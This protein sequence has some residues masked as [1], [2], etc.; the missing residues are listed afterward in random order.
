MMENFFTVRLQDQEIVFRKCESGL[1]YFD[2]EAVT[3]S[4]SAIITS[5]D[6]STLDKTCLLSTM[7]KNRFWFTPYQF[8]RYRL[9]RRIYAM[10]CR[11]SCRDFQNVVHSH[12]IKNI[13][14]TIE[15]ITVT[16]SIFGLDLS[17]LKNK[18][19]RT[20]PS[21]VVRNYAS[22]PA[23]IRLLHHYVN[24]SV[25]I[26]Y[27]KSLLLLVTV[28]RSLKY[29]TLMLIKSR[30]R[31]Q[32]VTGITTVMQLYTKYSFVVNFING[33]NKFEA[34]RGNLTKVESILPHRKNTSRR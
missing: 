5:F 13:L 6:D 29:T 25:G 1:C 30:K 12:R 4:N 31:L 19:V 26:M 2:A 28:S 16:N 3:E 14:L 34:I 17:S 32:L 11:T 10:I 33:K 21:L 7:N 15:D 22:V 23:P 24:I 20:T 8:S 9:A 27:M 18:T